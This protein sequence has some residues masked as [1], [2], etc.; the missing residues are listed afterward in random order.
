MGWVRIQRTNDAP[1]KPGDLCTSL[2]GGGGGLYFVPHLLFDDLSFSLC[3]FV[4]HPQVLA[5]LYPQ[6][7]ASTLVDA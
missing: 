3:A 7:S 1:G 2:E 5:G 4:F 6:S